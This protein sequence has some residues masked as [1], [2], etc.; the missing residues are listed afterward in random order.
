MGNI[1]IKKF[2]V[3]FV[4]WFDTLEE[5]EEEQEVFK[6]VSGA[7]CLSAPMVSSIISK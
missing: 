4:S 2:A 7:K 5:D 1:H 6:L 3:T